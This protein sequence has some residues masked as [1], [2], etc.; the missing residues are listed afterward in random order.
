MALLKLSK[1][2]E[3][4]LLRD[5]ISEQQELFVQAASA[6][7]KNTEAPKMVCLKIA[8]NNVVAHELLAEGSRMN[9]K[10]ENYLNAQRLLSGN[11]QT[12]QRLIELNSA[13]Q[14]NRGPDG[15]FQSSR[16]HFD[17][18]LNRDESIFPSDYLNFDAKMKR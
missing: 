17:M 15:V 14:I 18:L 11:A 12:E 4:D 9:P 2:R 16:L 10:I 7:K 1:T 6:E 8:P 5:S 13:A 3:D